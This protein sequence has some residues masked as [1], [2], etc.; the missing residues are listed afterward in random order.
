VTPSAP[1]LAEPSTG[2]VVVAGCRMRV[3]TAGTGEPLLHL[4][5]VGDLVGDFLTGGDRR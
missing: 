2:A 5:G 4:H 3:L 1:P